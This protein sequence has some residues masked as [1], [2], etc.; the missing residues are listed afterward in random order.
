MIP[1]ILTL[2]CV[3]CVSSRTAP[4]YP[5]RLRGGGLRPLNKPRGIHPINPP[6]YVGYVE[7]AGFRNRKRTK[8]PT[9]VDERGDVHASAGVDFRWKSADAKLGM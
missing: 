2:D 4:L 8:D 3:V 9:T 5:P 1:P 6:H 7:A